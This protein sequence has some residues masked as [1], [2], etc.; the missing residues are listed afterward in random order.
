MIFKSLKEKC[1]YYRSLTD[2]RL[3]PNGYVIVMIDGKNFSR[4][5]KNK[6]EKPFDDWFIS[7]MNG[8]A[9]HVMKSIQGCVGAFVQSDEISILIKDTGETT[10]PFDGRMCKLLSII[11]ATATSYFMKQIIARNL[12]TGMKID[13]IPDHVFDCKVWNVPTKN[14]AL[15][16]FIYRQNDCVKNSKQQ[17][18]QTYLPH[19][20]LMGLNTDMQVTLCETETGHDWTVLPKDRQYGRFFSRVLTEMTNGDGEKYYRRVISVSYPNL[21][22]P[23]E[24][25]ELMKLWGLTEEKDDNDMCI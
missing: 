17:F 20:K 25:Y 19:G 22:V 7:T 18:C 10:M 23:E 1:E 12:E 15:A 6:F 21:N 8:T 14:D 16:W 9:E 24:R 3:V 13:D 4:L 5:I 11:P 2:Y